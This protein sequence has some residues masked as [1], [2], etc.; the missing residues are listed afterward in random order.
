[1]GGCPSDP[2]AVGSACLSWAHCPRRLQPQGDEKHSHEHRGLM[3]VHMRTPLPMD[4]EK[5]KLWPVSPP[6]I[7]L[8][9]YHTS[10]TILRGLGSVSHPLPLPTSVSHMGALPQFGHVLPKALQNHLGGPI[11]NMYV[12]LTTS[13]LVR[14]AERSCSHQISF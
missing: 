2:T 10:E 12:F 5:W 8:R 7:L 13:R 4:A 3:E 1:M 9:H 6:T 14:D 11:F